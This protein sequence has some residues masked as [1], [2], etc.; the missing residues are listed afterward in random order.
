MCAVQLYDLNSRLVSLAVLCSCALSA[1]LGNDINGKAG[2]DLLT[3][4][5]AGRAGCRPLLA[6][7]RVLN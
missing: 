6:T 2:H 3:A 5:L 4:L 7:Q 1:P